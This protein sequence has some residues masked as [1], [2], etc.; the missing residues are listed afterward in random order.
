MSKKTSYAKDADFREWWSN[1]SK[2]ERQG[3]L[4]QRDADEIAAPHDKH[5]AK[6]GG[7]VDEVDENDNGVPTMDN[8]RAEIL[9]YAEDNELDFIED[10]T[11][12]EL[13]EVI[14]AAND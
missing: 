4:A 3:Y 8:T 13:L 7:E 1:A 2:A 14:N 5:A 12:A 10:M 9:A 6:E 11:K